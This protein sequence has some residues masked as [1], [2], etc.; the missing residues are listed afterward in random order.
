MELHVDEPDHTAYRL[1]GCRVRHSLDDPAL[2]WPP[3][4]EPLVPP[5]VA[6]ALVD[7]PDPVEE[8]LLAELDEELAADERPLDEVPEEPVLSPPVVVALVAPVDPA[9]FPVEPP[10]VP[11][12][13]WIAPLDPAGTQTLFDSQTTSG[14]AGR[15]ATET[16]HARTAM[17]RVI[18]VTKYTPPPPRLRRRSR[19]AQARRW[20]SVVR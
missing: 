4:V 14:G 8:P 17:G 7:V 19:A 15:Q 1:R 11:A 18:L 10:E 20:P 2:L 13:T 6:P 3:V 12:V 16:R 5:V 9:P